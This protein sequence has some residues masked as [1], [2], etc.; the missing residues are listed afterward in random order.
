MSRAGFV[1]LLESEDGGRILPIHIGTPEAQA[2]LFAQKGIRIPR[3]LTHDLLRNLLHVLGARLAKVVI[4]DLR[5][6]TFYAVLFL[7]FGGKVLQVDARPSDGIALAI[8]MKAPLFVAPLVME[9]AGLSPAD[10][11]D[12]THAAVSDAKSSGK[13]TPVSDPVEHL[14]QALD[15][16]VREERYE[17]AARIR[18]EIQKLTE[19]GR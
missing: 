1:V 16:A 17:D 10:L 18:D 5:E 2:I 12:D 14:R 13:S 6:H 11:V 3:P 9:Q 8:R 15:V 19:T 7:E 4:H